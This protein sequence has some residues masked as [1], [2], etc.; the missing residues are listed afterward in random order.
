MPELSSEEKRWKTKHELVL[1][2]LVGG[3]AFVLLGVVALGFAFAAIAAASPFNEV[4]A[5]AFGRLATVG[6]VCL[7]GG[8]VV[9]VGSWFARREL[10]TSRPTRRS[11]PQC[12]Q[13]VGPGP[14]HCPECG[15]NLASF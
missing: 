9:A 13:K 8:A 10:E 15:A 4:Q 7:V 11:C 6:L 5:A 12:G 14:K 2:G 1:G 3:I